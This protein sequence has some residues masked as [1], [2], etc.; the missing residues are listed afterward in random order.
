[1]DLRLLCDP[2]SFLH[3]GYCLSC[4]LLLILVYHWRQTPYSSAFYSLE[5]G[6]KCSHFSVLS[7]ENFIYCLLIVPTYF[8]A[9]AEL[10]P[11]NVHSAI[12]GKSTLYFSNKKQALCTNLSTHYILMLLLSTPARGSEASSLRHF[13]KICFL[14]TLT[15][16]P[17]KAI[18]Y[19]CSFNVA[20][21]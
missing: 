18:L 6:R 19:R 20:H 4:H 11:S 13:H 16:Y 9:C 1:M 15:E 21:L 7:K 17:I 10:I 3:E 8:L 14:S 5:L 12:W 2:S